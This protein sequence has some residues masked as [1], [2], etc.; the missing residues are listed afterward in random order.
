MK[1]L[2]PKQMIAQAAAAE[3]KADKAAKHAAMMAKHAER[4]TAIA[5]HEA[6]W[7]LWVAADCIGPMPIHPDNVGMGTGVRAHK[8]DDADL[9]AAAAELGISL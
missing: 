1:K 8:L 7:D 6:A 5:L 4:R 9:K 3:R 2:T